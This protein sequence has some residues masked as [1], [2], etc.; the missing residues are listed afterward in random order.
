MKKTVCIILSLVLFIGIFS[1]TGL[2]AG[3]KVSVPTPISSDDAQVKWIQ[4][5]GTSYLD[6]PSSVT[7]AGDYLMIMSQKSLLKIDRSSG[8]TVASA[9]MTDVP[10]FTYVPVC[11]SNG[12]VYCPL[13]NA[14][15]Q[16]FDVN[17]MKSLWVYHDSLGGQSLTPIVEENGKI[18]TGFWNDED[19]NASFVCIDTKD[20]NPSNST[21][22]KNADWTYK[23]LGGFYRTECKIIGDYLYVGCD[24]GTIYSDKASKVLSLNKKTG[25]LSDYVDTIGDIRSGVTESSG[26]LFFVS[27]AGYLYSVGASGGKFNKSSLKKLSLG[28][29]ATSTPLINNGRIYVGVRANTISSG[30]VKVIDEK[31]LKVIYSADVRGYAQSDFLLSDYYEKDTGKVYIY[32]TYNYPPGG[33]CALVDSSGQTVADVRDIYVPDS[34]QSAYCISPVVADKDGTLYFKND[35]GNIFAIS[36]KQKKEP[37]KS[38]FRR[39]IEWIVSVFQKIK[40][41]F[42]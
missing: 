11:Y 6:A 34:S 5:F 35:S 37:K 15:I 32:L 9:Q 20:E 7:I 24:D 18:Y 26:N 38:F 31:S 28:G 29:S 40:N 10:G 3:G 27:K 2:A 21:E 25:K 33:M 4:R 36:K 22:E 13:D 12:V 30:Y 16:A 42:S 8:K 41:L 19:K 1:T 23:S 14:T 39:I 17:T